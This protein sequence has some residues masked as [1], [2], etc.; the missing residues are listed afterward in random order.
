MEIYFSEGDHSVHE[1]SEL[2]LVAQISKAYGILLATPITINIIPMTIPKAKAMGIAIPNTYI[3]NDPRSPSYAGI[4]IA[5]S[6]YFTQHHI[7]LNNIITWSV[8]CNVQFLQ[9]KLILM[10]PASM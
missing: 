8:T 3:F 10:P 7:T 5:Y 2:V 1:N 9:L 4:N 6:L